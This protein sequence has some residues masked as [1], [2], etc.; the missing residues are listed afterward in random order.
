MDRRTITIGDLI[1]P[2]PPMDLTQAPPR[3]EED[4]DAAGAL[5]D[6]RTGSSAKIDQLVKLL[7]LT[8]ANE[9]SLVFSQFTTFLD[10]IAEALDE[11]GIDYCRF[12]GQMSARRRQETLD[13]FSVPLAEGE[14]DDMPALTPR[15][16]ARP[17]ASQSASV[18]TTSSRL[19]RRTGSQKNLFDGDEEIA[20]GDDDDDF[21]LG[22]GN[23][24]DDDF[25]D[26]DDDDSPFASKSKKGKGKTKAKSKG[27]GK[28]V[29]SKKATYAPL[30]SGRNPKVML[31][32]L[33]VRVYV[34]RKYDYGHERIQAGALGL[35]L[36][37]ANNVYLMDPWWQ[38]GIES[39]AIDRCNRI[40]QTKPVHVFQLIAED[41]V[42][43][44]V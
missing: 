21:V 25:I 18:T 8:P 33:K 16:R 22:A 15:A 42:E 34:S 20:A 30:P 43:S 5:H 24:E 12:D 31:I 35:N 4:E 37:V 1:E 17:S 19:R 38:E 41:T 7:E 9:K 32:S 2:A 13:A 26:D 27:K 36:T 11:A 10:K 40:G 28:A 6:L 23:D 14:Q 39:Q 3:L 29:R 44:K